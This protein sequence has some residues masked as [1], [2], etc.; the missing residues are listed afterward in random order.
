MKVRRESTIVTVLIYLPAFRNP[1]RSG[2]RI[3][4]NRRLLRQTAEDVA[5]ELG[6]G[7]TLYDFGDHPPT[8]FWW[9]RGLVSADVIRMLEVDMEDT[10]ANRSWIREYARSVLLSR[11]GQKAIYI[12]FVTSVERLVVTDEMVDG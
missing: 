10:E 2:R 8:G 7:G 3:P 6:E 1:D 9:D 5:R 4:V 11:F 12:K